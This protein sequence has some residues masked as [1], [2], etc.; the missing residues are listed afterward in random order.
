MR[1]RVSPID[2]RVVRLDVPG[3][4]NYNFH[5]AWYADQDYHAHLLVEDFNRR[6]DAAMREARATAYAE[7]WKDAKA[8]TKKQESF[9]RWLEVK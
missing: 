5:F 4:L 1:F 7:G 8:K 6:L 3:P 9:S 2:K